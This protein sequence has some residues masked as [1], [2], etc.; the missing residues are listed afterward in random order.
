MEEM[1]KILFDETKLMSVRHKTIQLSEKSG[2]SKL[3]D[4]GF[5]Q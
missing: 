2:F 5:L 3:C 4:K 1:I